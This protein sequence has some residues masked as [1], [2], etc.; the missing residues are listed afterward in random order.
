MR[1]RP[2]RCF[3]ATLAAALLTAGLMGCGQ[4]RQEAAAPPPIAAAK[5]AEPEAAPPKP[6]AEAPATAP[7]A[8]ATAPAPV[9]VPAPTAPTAKPAPAFTPGTSE[10]G[11]IPPAPAPEATRKDEAK[12]VDS[13]QW[14]RD[15][16]ARESDYKRRLEEAEVNLAAADTSAAQWE[17]NLLAFKNPF[18]PRPQLSPE[19]AQTI[20]GMD[21]AGRA[22]W[23]EGRLTDARVKRNAAQKAL[24]DLKANPPL[25]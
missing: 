24:D 16:Q 4:D 9:A 23:A 7:P 6:A 12:P 20:Q 8:A 1:R 25:N 3:D 15:K 2:A 5:P 17:R 14:M 22:L 21:G 19:D 18:L 11:A 10:P 13:L